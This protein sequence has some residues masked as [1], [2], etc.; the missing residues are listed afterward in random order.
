MTVVDLLCFSYFLL[1]LDKCLISRHACFHPSR[2]SRI[3]SFW[4]PLSLGSLCRIAVVFLVVQWK[5]V[6]KD[7]LVTRNALLLCE[8]TIATSSQTRRFIQLTRHINMIISQVRPRSPPKSFYIVPTSPILQLFHSL[9]P[10]PSYQPSTTM[11]QPHVRQTLASFME[12]W[13]NS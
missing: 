8:L 9:I 3:C 11:M 5:R 12:S 2:F 6:L 1:F 7:I 13:H 4:W 10:R